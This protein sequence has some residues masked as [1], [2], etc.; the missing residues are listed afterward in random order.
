MRPLIRE[1]ALDIAVVGGDRRESAAAAFFVEQGA[2]VRMYGPPWQ[3]GL[4]GA[5]QARSLADAIEGARVIVG[6]VKGIDQDNHLYG[7]PGLPGLWVTPAVMEKV[8]PDAVFFIGSANAWLRER[9]PERGFRLVELLERDDF[10][11]L[12][13]IP[14]AEG[15]VQKAMEESDVT[16]FGNE[17]LVVG[18]GRTG[19][20]LSSTLRGLGGR[21]TVAARDSGDLARVLACGYRPL[22][23][24]DLA[25]GAEVADFIFNTVPDLVLTRAVLARTRATVVI[26]DIASA[27]GGTDFAA[28]DALGRRAFLTPGLPGKVAPR[29]AGRYLAQVVWQQVGEMLAVPRVTPWQ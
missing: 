1:A 4:A 9:A 25:E 11:I 19:Q 10:S 7:A 18:F 8:A 6:P 14:T 23:S 29:T 28:A 2:A 17:S 26:V 15:A 16:I 5:R 27:P 21:V 22:A 13:S 3:D 20:T 24:A 12:N